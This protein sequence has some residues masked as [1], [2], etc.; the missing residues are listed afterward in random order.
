MSC[1]DYAFAYIIRFEMQYVR[2]TISNTVLKFITHILLLAYKLFIHFSYNA[3]D[4][5]LID[6]IVSDVNFSNKDHMS[7]STIFF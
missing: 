6:S 3:L 2:L 1:F 5:N 7:Y 4:I